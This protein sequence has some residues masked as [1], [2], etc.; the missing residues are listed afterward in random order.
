MRFG[1]LAAT[2]LAA[3]CALLGC[4][5]NNGGSPSSGGSGGSGTGG[6]SS[7]GTGNGGSGGALPPCMPTAAECYVSGPHGPGAECMA[8][9]DNGSATTWQGRLSDLDVSAPAALAAQ[10]VQTVIIDQGLNF[11][12]TACNQTGLGTFNWLFEYDSVKHTLKTGG[13][14]PVSDPTKGDCYAVIPNSNPALTVG[15][16]TVNVTATGTQFS[17][18]NIDVVV[19]L[20]AAAGDT[21]PSILLPLHKVSLEGTWTA[22]HDCIGSYD[23]ADLSTSNDCEAQYPKR[24]WKTGGTLSGYILITEAD[25][26]TIPQLNGE[27]LCVLLT[28]DPNTWEGPNN[29]CASSSAWKAGQ[30]PKGDWCSS[31][32]A[33][34]TASC[35][36]A[37]HLQANFAAQAFKVTGN[38]P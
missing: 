30:R 28:G 17:G 26:V 21:S 38:C 4:S 16:Q 8:R 11:K 19:P 37:Y 10:L 34:A 20:Y 12:E 2:A 7:G 29:D 9:I 35:S 14:P 1:F 24:D 13:G 5:S 25:Q 22:D 27:T 23:A 3:T 18:S 6:S 15:P 36:D 31:T 33:A 32:N